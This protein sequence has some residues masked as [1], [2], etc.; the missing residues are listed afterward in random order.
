MLVT[1]AS[2]AIVPGIDNPLLTR[3][4]KAF[5]LAEFG[6]GEADI[7]SKLNGGSS[8]ELCLTLGMAYMNVHPTFLPGE[9]VKSELTITKE[10]G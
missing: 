4:N 3:L 2:E 6:C 8:P 5:D 9:E 1:S 7:T 10:G